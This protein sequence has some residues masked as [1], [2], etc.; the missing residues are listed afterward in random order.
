MRN[1]PK[2]QD[3]PTDRYAPGDR[4]V[5]A[6]QGVLSYEQLVS[7]RKSIQKWAQEDVRILLVSSTH[8]CVYLKRDGQITTIVDIKSMPPQAPLA[9][10]LNLNCGVVSLQK[11]DQVLGTLPVGSTSS[12]LRRFRD[13]LVDW[14]GPDVEVLVGPPQYVSEILDKH[15]KVT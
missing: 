9:G 7:I 3:L 12:S 15:K 13:M 1:Q 14:A 11:D 4:I 6:Y 2:L 8:S 10:K 5:A